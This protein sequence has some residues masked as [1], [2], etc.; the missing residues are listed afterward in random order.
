[1]E[2]DNLER[3]QSFLPHDAIM[4]GNDLVEVER[5]KLNS[6]SEKEAI[7]DL[8][9]APVIKGSAKSGD[10]DDDSDLGYSDGKQLAYSLSFVEVLMRSRR[11]GSQ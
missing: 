10:V 7:E 9:K 5:S 2:V 4:L 3:S 6:Y 1:M 11:D 8:S